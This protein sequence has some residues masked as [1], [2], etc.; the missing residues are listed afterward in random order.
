VTTLAQLRTRAQSESDNINSTFVANSEWLDFINQSL[1]ETYGLFAQAYGN[2]YFFQSP[3]GGYTFT[4]DGINNF[5]NLPADFWKLLGIDVQVASPSQWVTLKKFPISDRN[6]LSVFNGPT[7]QAGQTLR[8][9][10]IPQLTPLAADSDT[11]PTALSQNGGDELIVIDAA[12]KALAKEE[13]DVSVLMARK[14]AIIQRLESEAENRDASQPSTMVD[15]FNR[16]ARGMMYHVTGSQ[17]WLI[18]SS[19]PGWA[20]GDWPS[21]DANGPWW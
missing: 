10:Y 11:I 7:P 13:S 21:E 16:R 15:V 9:F 2:D 8:V 19:T 5:F 14:A 1:F 3:S 12:M 18:G 6:R 20:N 4:T 17:I